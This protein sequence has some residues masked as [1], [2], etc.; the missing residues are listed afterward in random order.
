[1]RYL[2]LSLFLC[3][4][5]LARAGTFEVVA[6][7]DHDHLE[8]GESL[9]LSLTLKVQ[10]QLDFPPQL[11]QPKFDGFDAQGPQQ[12]QNVTWVNGAVSIQQGLVWELTA[13]KAGTLTLGPY[14]IH[15]KSAK[16]GDVTKA[17]QPI[18][19][20]VSRPKGLNF[21]GAQ[22]QPTVDLSRVPGTAPNP[23]DGLRD[24]KPDRPF[25]WAWVAL[26]AL[27]GLGAMGGFLTWW[28]RRPK[29]PPPMVVKRDPAQW[30]LEQIEKA[31]QAAAGDLDDATLNKVAELLR[32]YLR[33]RFRLADEVTLTEALR[34]ALRTVPWQGLEPLLA[35]RD[36]LYRLLYGGEGTE[37][38]PPAEFFEAARRWVLLTETALSGSVALKELERSLKDQVAEWDAGRPKGAW[39]A[40]R[41]AFMRYLKA[42]HG[43]VDAEALRESLAQDLKDLEVPDLLDAA[44]LTFGDK[45][46]EHWSGTIAAERLLQLGRAMEA[47]KADTRKGDGHGE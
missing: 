8:L 9:Q 30:A 43:G 21:P 41:A 7:V 20:H 3:L 39:S 5:Q 29:A 16:N 34:V 36:R 4:S 10:G 12:R 19:I 1:M 18:T 15:A 17:T 40:M 13:M 33:Q 47:A 11:E 2:L 28:R 26:G 31:R 23:D 14:V 6:S 25:P 27:L 42:R 45:A 38:T 44:E 24:I 37:A 32:Q 35:E 46:P 22:P